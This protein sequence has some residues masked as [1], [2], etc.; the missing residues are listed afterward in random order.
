MGDKLS[1]DGSGKQATAG[2]DVRL[3]DVPAVV[4]EFGIFE[5]LHGSVSSAEFVDRVNKA[6]SAH[7]GV[8]GPAFVEKV[9]ENVDLVTAEAARF[10]GKFVARELPEGATGQI[11]RVAKRFGLLALAGTLA[12]RPSSSAR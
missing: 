3:L 2:I 10:N 12:I 4:G 8:A 11:V 6:A 7:Y 5:T 9:I 1:E